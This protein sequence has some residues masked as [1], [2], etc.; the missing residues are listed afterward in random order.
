MLYEIKQQEAIRLLKAT[1]QDLQDLFKTAPHAGYCASHKY[2]PRE[3]LCT[4]TPTYAPQ[5]Y[6]HQNCDCWKKEVEQ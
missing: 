3:C 6:E 4:N 1:T 5:T 2:K